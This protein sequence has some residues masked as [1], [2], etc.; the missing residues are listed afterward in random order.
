MA[1][2]APETWPFP[3]DLLPDD[4]YLVGGSVR[5]RLLHRS[6]VYLD[7]DFVLRDAVETAAKIA[8]NC[9]AGFVVLD[10]RRQIARVVFA[11]TTVDFAA[12]QGDSIEADLGRRDFTINA[13]AYHPTHHQLLDPLDGAADLASKTL[14]MVAEENLTADPLRMMRAYR[15][16]AQLGF[17]ITPETQKAIAQIAPRLILV[18]RERVRKEL[19][20]LLSVPASGDYLQALLESKLLQSCL[21]HFNAKS[22]VQVQAI[23][24]AMSRLR[25]QMPAYAESLQG[26]LA[27]VP[28]GYFRSWIKVTKLSQLVSAEPQR[29]IDEL[30]ALKYSRSEAQVVAALLTAQPHIAAMQQAPLTRAQQFFLFKTANSSFPAV[31]LLA[32]AQ[33]VSLKRLRPLI[34]RFL[35]PNDKVAHA[36]SL[37]SGTTLMEKLKLTPGPQIGE[38]LQA[39]EQA[40]AEG[41]LCDEESAIAFAKAWQNS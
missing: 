35:D 15:Q 22:V 29:A 9:D 39:V 30:M 27:P 38:V 12:Q 23:E 31:S 28:V 4:A 13:I 5:D 11:Q 1:L 6:A 26:W 2:F 20:A 14:R 7:L 37:I 33:G 8:R 34:E 25:S 40:Q 16:A 18:A 36:P 19:D 17:S 24:S 10:E 41:E 32:M 21:P 3:V